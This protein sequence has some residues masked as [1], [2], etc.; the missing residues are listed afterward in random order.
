MRQGTGYYVCGDSRQKSVEQ[1]VARILLDRGTACQYEQ[2][3]ALYPVEAAKCSTQRIFKS[4][5]IA[6]IYWVFWFQ[7]TRS[8]S[9][10]VQASGTSV[11]CAAVTRAKD[12]FQSAQN[13]QRDAESRLHFAHLNSWVPAKKQFKERVNF[14]LVYS[15]RWCSLFR[16]V[17]CSS[18]VAGFWHLKNWWQV[19]WVSS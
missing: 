6:W 2:A 17:T 13:C 14:F 18:T 8:V 12:R 5:N 19:A 11:P 4:E 10:M 7:Y 16:R 1:E 3:P 15:L 9:K